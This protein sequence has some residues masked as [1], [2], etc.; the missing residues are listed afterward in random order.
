[1][2]KRGDGIL[3]SVGPCLRDSKSTAGG[4]GAFAFSV[5]GLIVSM[6]FT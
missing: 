5:G 4:C 2:A 1:M 3:E 6:R